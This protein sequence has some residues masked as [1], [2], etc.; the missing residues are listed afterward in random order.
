MT[1]PA[2]V[3]SGASPPLN[4]SA[5]WRNENVL[6]AGYVLQLTPFPPAPGR[7]AS[8]VEPRLQLIRLPR[9]GFPASAGSSVVNVTV[10]PASASKA[11]TCHQTVDRSTSQL[12]TW[13]PCTSTS[14]LLPQPSVILHSSFCILHSL[15][16]PVGLLHTF[17]SVKTHPFQSVSIRAAGPVGFW[18]SAE[19]SC[20]RRILRQEVLTWWNNPPTSPIGPLSAPSQMLPARSL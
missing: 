9:S 3:S 17:T 2:S 16:T 18:R 12:S 20:L 15:T 19:R 8:N 1:A 7:R 10:I 4:S 5:A 11:S 13:W 14:Q 6:E